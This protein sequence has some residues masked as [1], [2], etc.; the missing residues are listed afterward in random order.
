MLMTDG[1]C[2]RILTTNNKLRSQALDPFL[3]S[4]DYPSE[5]WLPTRILTTRLNVTAST[6]TKHGKQRADNH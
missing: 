6:Q 3:G 5:S 2:Y 4:A 1:T